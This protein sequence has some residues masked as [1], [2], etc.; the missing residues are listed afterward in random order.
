[1]HLTKEIL[2]GVYNEKKNYPM[3]DLTEIVRAISEFWLPHA[4]RQNE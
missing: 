3:L 1:M 2:N 4:D